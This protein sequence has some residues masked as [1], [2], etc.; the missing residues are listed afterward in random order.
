MLKYTT[1]ILTQIQNKLD[2]QVG[3]GGNSTTILTKF[4]DPGKLRPYSTE[5]NK[6]KYT[7]KT[8]Q[9]IHSVH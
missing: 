1:D 3:G 6:S 2:P 5:R 9:F 8:F 7:H 4:Y